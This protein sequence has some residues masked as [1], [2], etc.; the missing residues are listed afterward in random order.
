MWEATA[1]IIIFDCG[2]PMKCQISKD[3]YFKNLMSHYIV[4]K[5]RRDG[6]Q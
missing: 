6:G 4:M 1:L 2:W 5:Y 3:Y